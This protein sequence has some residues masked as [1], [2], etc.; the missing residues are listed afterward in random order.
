MINFRVEDKN[1]VVYIRHGI[2]GSGFF[3]QKLVCSEPWIAILLYR[4][5]EKEMCDKLEKIRRESYEEGWRDA[6]AKK[7]GKKT[8]FSRLW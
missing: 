8:W 7:S 5:L 1:V 2:T 6:K 4:Q 3:E